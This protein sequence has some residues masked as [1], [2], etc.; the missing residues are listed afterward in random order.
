[1]PSNLRKIRFSFL[2]HYFMV[3]FKINYSKEQL[4]RKYNHMQK[5]ASKLI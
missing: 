5:I 4:W 2:L 3:Y 1:M